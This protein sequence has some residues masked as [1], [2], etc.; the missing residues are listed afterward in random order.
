MASSG[1]MMASR[2]SG[3]GIIRKRTSTTKTPSVEELS[4]RRSSLRKSLESGLGEDDGEEGPVKAR[5][6]PFFRKFWPHLDRQASFSKNSGTDDHEK[7][8]TTDSLHSLNTTFYGK[9]V[10]EVDPFIFEDVSSTFQFLL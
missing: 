3:G 10:E 4:E 9:P 1:S 6:M 2:R 7:E 5:F 8:E